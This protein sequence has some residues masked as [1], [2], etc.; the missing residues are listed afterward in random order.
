MTSDLSTMWDVSAR[1][2]CEIYMKFVFVLRLLMEVKGDHR[3]KFHIYSHHYTQLVE[4]CLNWKIYC[5][6]HSLL[7]KV[8]FLSLMKC[9]SLQSRAHLEVLR[10]QFSLKNYWTHHIHSDFK[11]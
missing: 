9:A 1:V 11:R 5:D 4:Q 8:S 7:S 10:P 3:S 6:D 2:L